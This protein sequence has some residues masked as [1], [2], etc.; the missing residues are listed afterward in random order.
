VAK[1]QVK[2]SSEKII[3]RVKSK[4][5]AVAKTET[6]PEQPSVTPIAREQPATTAG[7]HLVRRWLS[8]FLGLTAVSLILASILFGWVNYT[9]LNNR[10]YL[11]TVAPL[12]SQPKIQAYLSKATTDAILDNNSPQ[13]LA[14]KLNIKLPVQ[15]P[16]N[17]LRQ[18]L[19]SPVEAAVAK[20]FYSPD[21]AKLWQQA[22]Q[23][24]HDQLLNLI[25]SKD[26]QGSL[27]FRPTVDGLIS[28]L[29]QTQLNFINLSDITASNAKVN[30]SA[31]QL[32]RLRKTYNASQRGLKAL[33]S[34]AVLTSVATVL[35]AN[36]RL[37]AIRH[38]ALGTS[39]GVALIILAVNLPGHLSLNGVDPTAKDALVA[40]TQTI[41]GSLAR[42]CWIVLAVSLATAAAATG[43]LWY[44]GRRLKASD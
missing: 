28:L 7:P 42:L 41:F 43:W 32:S 29:R 9:L 24:A 18:Q 26:S 25:R 36:Q 3:V 31:D 44:S 23:S 34:L 13:D 33:L 14:A 35:V 5:V 39:L 10:Q 27:D 11:A 19:R 4:S 15:V 8:A 40:A 21:F 38:M 30:L 1:T 17:L 12:A 20:V 6:E 2:D 37:K 22:N 16:D